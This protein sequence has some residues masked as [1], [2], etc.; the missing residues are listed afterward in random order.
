MLI[1]LTFRLLVLAALA[2]PALPAHAG[3]TE[4]SDRAEWEAAVGAFTTIDFTG[5]PAFTIIT[6]QYQDLG[7]T[8]TDGND[9]TFF[10]PS[11]VNDNWGLDG[12][13]DIHLSFER[14][15]GWIG[16]DFPGDVRVLL[17]SGGEL[18]H[19]S[20]FFSAGPD[21]VGGFA[22]LVS[23]ELFDA[24]VILDRVDDAVFIDDLHF[25]V[26]A[27]GGLMLLALAG[28]WPRRRRR[29]RD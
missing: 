4:F 27:P 25:G 8:F 9:V 6:D 17:F 15:Q 5:F 3:V 26:P 22:G 13:G 24:A 21:G 2:C 1:R 19:F 14:P 23:T 10:T 16:V 18:I 12:N 20:S 28:I 7:V 11:F 29:S